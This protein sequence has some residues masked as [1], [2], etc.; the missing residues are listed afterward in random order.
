MKDN[1]DAHIKD[2]ISRTIE[3]EHGHNLI[4][5]IKSD[6]VLPHPANLYVPMYIKEE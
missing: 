3:L 1:M 6:D 4:F 5:T 2:L